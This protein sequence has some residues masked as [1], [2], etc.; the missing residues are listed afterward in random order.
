MTN[1]KA[2]FRPWGALAALLLLPV[3]TAQSQEVDNARAY[4]L[5]NQVADEL[6]LVRERMGRPG[7]SA[8]SGARGRG[9]ALA[10][11]DPVGRR[12]R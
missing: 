2:C 7:Q 1:L 4:A 9:A 5:A 8:R 3:V 6:E 11:P 10:R 12:G